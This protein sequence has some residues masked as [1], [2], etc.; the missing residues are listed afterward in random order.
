LY[1]LSSSSG[2]SCEQPLLIYL[3]LLNLI[4][5]EMMFNQNSY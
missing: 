1:A 3:S 5:Y 2:R 4:S